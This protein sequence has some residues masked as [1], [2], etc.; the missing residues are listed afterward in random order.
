MREDRTYI[1]VHYCAAE[2]IDP[3]VVRPSR[4][5]FFGAVVCVLRTVEDFVRIGYK[6]HAGNPVIYLQS[7]ISICLVPRVQCQSRRKIE[8]TAVRD[9]IFIVV[10]I[11]ECEDLPPES[12]IACCGIVSRSLCIEDSLRKSQP[13]RTPL[14]RIWKFRL[15]SSHCSHSPEPLIIIPFCFRLIERHKICVVASLVEEGLCSYG[16]VGCV[17]GVVPIVDHG[18]EPALTL[19]VSALTDEFD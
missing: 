3:C 4:V 16:V 14:R 12:S 1:V 15:R 17:A 9:S 13:S 5:V 2:K 11:V 10:A 6:P 7:P 8:E 19:V 18:S